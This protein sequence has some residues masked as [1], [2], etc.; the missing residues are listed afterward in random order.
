MKLII[1]LFAGCMIANSANAQQSKKDTKQTTKKE[2]KEET[3]EEAKAR[4]KEYWK[5]VGNNQRD[6]WKGEHEK[7]VA[8]EEGREAKE[9]KRKGP[10]RPPSP[11]NPFKKK[12]KEK[13]TD[14]AES[15]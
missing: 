10:P 7:H 9:G 1:I 6:F 4:H 12:N 8:K 5:K 3:D 13:E 2:T 14:K 11:P 15:K